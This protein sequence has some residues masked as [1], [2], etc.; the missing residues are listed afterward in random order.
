MQSI[1]TLLSGDSSDSE[2]A[3]DVLERHHI[4]YTPVYSTTSTP[5]ALYGGVLYVGVDGITTLASSLAAAAS[6]GDRK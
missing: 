1:V 2:Q 3:R 5:K 6:S 4:T